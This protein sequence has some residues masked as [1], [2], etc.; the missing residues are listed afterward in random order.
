[1]FDQVFLTGFKKFGNCEVNPTELICEELKKYE[2]GGVSCR[3]I[4]VT[5]EDVDEY[6]EQTKL[7]QSGES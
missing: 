2:L 4:E 7:N 5:V 1:M 6:I 3:T